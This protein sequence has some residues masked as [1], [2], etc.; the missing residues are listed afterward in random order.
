MNSALLRDFT[1][2]EIYGALQSMAPSSHMVL[3]QTGSMSSKITQIR[4]CAVTQVG[5]VGILV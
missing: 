2:E 5:S 4:S 1:I 3:N